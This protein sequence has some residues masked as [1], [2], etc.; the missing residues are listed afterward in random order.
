MICRNIWFDELK[1]TVF[2]LKAE[3][4]EVK[5][6]C[7]CPYKIQTLDLKHFQEQLHNL[8]EKIKSLEKD[9][10]FESLCKEQGDL[11]GDLR[12]FLEDFSVDAKTTKLNNNRMSKSSSLKSFTERRNSKNVDYNNIQDLHDLLLKTGNL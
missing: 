10:Y 7:K 5:S 11:E 12:K 1:K 2:N 8:S 9:T 4:E 3:V 6:L